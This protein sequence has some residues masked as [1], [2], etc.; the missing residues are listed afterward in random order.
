MNARAVQE[1]R[2]PVRGFR[3][4]NNPARQ[5]R[6]FETTILGFATYDTDKKKFEAFEMV[7]LGSRWGATQFNGRERDLEAGPVGVAL[8]LSSG[9]SDER[10][11]PARIWE[12]D[13]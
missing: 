11:A 9:R 1:G 12:Y 7:A 5:E 3:D 6:G 2:W 8:T 4:N 13:W 10:V